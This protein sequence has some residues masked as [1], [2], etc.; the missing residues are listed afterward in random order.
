MG[1]RVVH[2][3]LDD[4]VLMGCHDVM[5]AGKSSIDN[6][7]MA[8]I[9]RSVLTALIRKLQNSQ[10]I[11]T[12]TAEELYERAME[13][14][15]GAKELDLD[16]TLSDIVKPTE[17]D[18]SSDMKALLAE[19][20][21][22]IENE[23]APE[24]IADESVEISEVDEEED[25]GFLALDLTTQTCNPFSYYLKAVPKDRFI[26]WAN[27]QNELIQKAVC[28]TYDGLPK[29]LWGS[30]KAEEMIKSLLERHLPK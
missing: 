7:P 22:E 27:S 17:E 30:D 5:K 29:Q 20:M 2:I 16:I 19:A 11:P 8:S 4:W 25:R 26:E 6:I 23:G 18:G 9:V 28:I 3:R 21:R 15:N 1:S 14:Y 24:G 12:Y 10:Q 13:L